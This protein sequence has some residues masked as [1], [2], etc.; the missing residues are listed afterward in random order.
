M[1]DGMSSV[2]LPTITTAGLNA[3]I[4]Q[5]ALGLKLEI[6]HVQVG[7]ASYT[8]TAGQSTLV[9]PRHSG[10]VL[11]SSASGNQVTGTARIMSAGYTGA[12]FDVCEIGFWAGDPNSGGTLV[13][14]MSTLPTAPYAVM[15]SDVR[16]DLLMLVTLQLDGVPAGSITLVMDPQAAFA[17]SLMAQHLSAANPHPQYDGVPIGTVILRHGA[18]VPRG[19]VVP[20]GSAVNRADY[21][22]LWAYAQAENLVVSDAAWASSPGFYSSGNGTTTFRLPEMRGEFLRAWDMGRGADPGRALGSMQA[23]AT[24]RPRSTY[25][26]ALLDNGTKGALRGQNQSTLS[27]A[28]QGPSTT[29]FVRVSKVGTVNSANG[30]DGNG[31]GAEMDVLNVIDGDV[32]TRPR[33]IALMPLIK[34]G[35]Q[36]VAAAPVVSTSPAPTAPPAPAPAPAPSAATVA[37]VAAFTGNPT[38]GEGDMV[39]T[40][41]D[42]SQNNP[43]AWLWDFGD[44]SQ[45]T[46]RNPVHVY[47]LPFNLRYNS[48]GLRYTV[49]LTATNSAGTDTETKTD[50]VWCNG[51]MGA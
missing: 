29:G 22:E 19:Y 51:I 27:A 49:T 41:V 5:N 39:V 28:G 6:T 13:M 42:Q 7:A 1:L 30:S 37:P 40:F 25:P 3:A 9:D 8:P 38:Y 10:L 47:E 32:E 44:G 34:A 20:N 33:N 45:S 48:S 35:G 18:T 36:S 4:S 14:V 16:T 24:A 23:D 46:D 43:T 50:F 31:A 26:Q 21:P 2:Y 11:G 17:A 15:G 12:R